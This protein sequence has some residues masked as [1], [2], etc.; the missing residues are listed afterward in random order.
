MFFIT[1]KLATET[2][3]IGTLNLNKGFI[4]RNLKIIT[5]TIPGTNTLLKFKLDILVIYLI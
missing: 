5:L 3:V 1:C 4:F 2:C